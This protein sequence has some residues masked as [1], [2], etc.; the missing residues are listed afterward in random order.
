MGFDFTIGVIVGSFTFMIVRLVIEFTV[1]TYGTL[2]IDHSNPEKDKYLI[3]IDNLDKLSRKKRV[4]LRID[5][6][7]DLSQK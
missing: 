2:K 6:K 3:E 7:A 5:H 4:S 1:T